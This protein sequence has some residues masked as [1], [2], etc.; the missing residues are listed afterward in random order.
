VFIGG[1]PAARLGD[2]TGCGAA[3][4]LGLFTVEIGG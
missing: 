4:I 1:M 3:I 2:M